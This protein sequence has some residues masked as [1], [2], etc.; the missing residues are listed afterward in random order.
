MDWALKRDNLGWFE[1]STRFGI[2]RSAKHNGHPSAR[3]QV[4]TVVAVAST[5]LGIGWVMA[6]DPIETPSATFYE[7][8]RV[9]LVNVEVVV[10]DR[11]GEPIL[12]LSQQDFEVLED[13]EPVEITHFFAAADQSSQTVAGDAS[14]RGPEML[15]QDL[16]LALYIDDSNVNL[17]HRTS[18]L[19]HLRDFLEQPL[20][21]KIKT[22]LVRFDGRLHVESGFSDQ[23]DQLIAAID[24]IQSQPPRDLSREGESL[25]RRMQSAGALP[26]QKVPTRPP[27]F[28]SSP[29]SGKVDE[30]MAFVHSNFLPEIHAHAGAKYAR[31]GASLQGLAEFVRYLRGIPGHKAVLWVGGFEMR[32]GENIFRTWQGLFPAEAR[33]QRV[34]PIRESIQYDMS[35]ELRKLVH[36]A[37]THD[38]SFYTLGSL[39]SGI[40]TSVEYDTRTFE[41]SGRPGDSGHLDVRGEHEAL[42]MMSEL[43]GGRMLMDNA[44]LGRQLEEVAT[45]LGSYYSLAYTPPSPGDGE[46]HKITVNLRR[47]GAQ[48]RYRQGYR[49]VGGEDRMAARTLA[50]AMLGVAANPLDIGVECQQQEARQDGTYLVPVMVRIPIGDLVLMPDA[51]SHVAQISLFS[52]V[53][54]DRGGLSDLHE[55]AYPIAIAND[56]LLSAVA[57]RAE[58]VVGM[59]LREGPHRIVVSV[60]DDHSLIESTGFVDVVVGTDEE[61][62]TG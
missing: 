2:M 51:G 7:P 49:D 11:D 17:R 60:R 30:T 10:T 38:V 16:Y 36:H 9:P 39:G 42:A 58:F 24:R 8:L 28:R 43:T 29:S 35:Q 4:A 20:P 56:Q 26:P 34:D 59:V 55:R 44:T 47:D 13:G 3:R 1:R 6:D 5:I 53:R 61:G 21:T 46:Y 22:L 12:G 31:S 57:Q 25:V 50:A 33:R 15:L 32:A 23:P 18:A 62:K 54:D 45:D 41:I 40:V 52:V 14:T 48:L 37:N 19:K 27:G